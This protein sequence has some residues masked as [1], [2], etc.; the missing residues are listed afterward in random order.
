MV[1]VAGDTVFRKDDVTYV[2]YGDTGDTV[3]L[4]AEYAARY[5]GDDYSYVMQDGEYFVAG[6]NRGNSHDSRDW[7]DSDDS[8]DVG[9]ID[10][11]MIV[12]H[13]RCVIWPLSEIR[14]ED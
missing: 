1:A 8:Q 5:S 4:D 11:S 12:G 6:D 14:G 7:N 10:E 2:T 9:P 13:V 3:A